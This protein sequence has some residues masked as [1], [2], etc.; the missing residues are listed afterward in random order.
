MTIHNDSKSQ[1]EL[2]LAWDG[3]QFTSRVQS[4][5]LVEEL[6][7]LDL[8][9][10]GLLSQA[11][12][13]KGA[14]AIVD[15]LAAGYGLGP[16]GQIPGTAELRSAELCSREF[17][18]FGMPR[19]REVQIHW[20]ADWPVGLRGQG[21]LQLANSLFL[22]SSPG[23]QDRL[24][25]RFDSQG[26]GTHTWTAGGRSQVL[27]GSPAQPAA[28]WQVL[29][30]HAWQG[31]AGLALVLALA[32]WGRGLGSEGGDRFTPGLKHWLWL[33]LPI[34]LL[35]WVLP[36]VGRPGPGGGLF[37]PLGVLYVLADSKLGGKLLGSGFA[38]ALWGA[39]F[40]VGAWAGECP[41]AGTPA[42][43]E[44]LW[45]LG[46]ATLCFVLGALLARLSPRRGVFHAAWIA[47]L[48]V[49]GVWA[50]GLWG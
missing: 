49:C 2:N 50:R 14:D 6:P 23:H 41:V 40:A 39:G 45:H 12:L 22:E 38:L 44:G 36:G 28:P 16:E 25:Y 1:T 27:V 13:E 19:L 37:L 18:G 34:A 21:D 33:V 30:S 8:D 46:A 4:L 3:L 29:A 5:S 26:G 43:P 31:G 7:G 42:I 35:A 11:E 48:L 15:C 17:D 9:G 20:V 47:A 10:D 32:C 24:T